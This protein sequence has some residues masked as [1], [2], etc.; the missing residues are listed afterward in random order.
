M[1]RL[2]ERANRVTIGAKGV[3]FLKVKMNTDYYESLDLPIVI[4]LSKYNIKFALFCCIIY[5][6]L[7]VDITNGNGGETS[8]FE[9]CI[10]NKITSY[11][12]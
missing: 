11:K 9:K 5:S 10:V 3:P 7:D 12:F 2:N 6:S 4:E 1:I 8:F